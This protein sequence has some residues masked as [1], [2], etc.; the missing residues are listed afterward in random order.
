MMIIAGCSGFGSSAAVRDS[1]GKSWGSTRR[2][3][4]ED[5]FQANDLCFED[6]RR[7]VVDAATCAERR[8]WASDVALRRHPR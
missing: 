1:R 8:L 2:T 4:I 3:T 5:R 7:R 6:A